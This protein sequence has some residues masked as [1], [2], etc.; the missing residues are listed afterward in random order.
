M[1][2]INVNDRVWVRLTRDGEKTLMEYLVAFGKSLPS[3]LEYSILDQL[4]Q[5]DEGRGWR[6]FPMS[7]LM[8]IF[9]PAMASNRRAMFDRNLIHFTRP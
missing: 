6:T 5:S 2:P 9:G 3:G 4:S 7:E 8:I 1:R